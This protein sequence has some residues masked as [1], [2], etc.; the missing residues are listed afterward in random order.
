MINSTNII[1]YDTP[2]IVIQND[3]IN[4]IE[5]S[6][7]FNIIDKFIY[8]VDY[9]TE[10]YE[11]EI[12]SINKLRSFNKEIILVINKDDNDKKNTNIKPFG[13]NQFF[14]ISCSHKI[15]FDDLYQYLESYDGSNEEIINEN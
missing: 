13:L 10:N 11:N 7:L 15:G 12:S 3:T 8:V 2:G 6:N 1:I 9:R 14:F 4:N 5:F